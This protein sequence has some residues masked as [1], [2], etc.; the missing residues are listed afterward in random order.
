MSKT[1]SVLRALVRQA[2]EKNEQTEVK[3]RALLSVV[4]NAGVGLLGVTVH[5]NPESMWMEVSDPHVCRSEEE[6]WRLGAV[7]EDDGNIVYLVAQHFV[8]RKVDPESAYWTKLLTLLNREHRRL[9][10]GRVWVDGEGEVCADH[11][12]VVHDGQL[13]VTQ[14]QRSIHGLF[15]LC[16]KLK[17][18]IDRLMDGHD[19]GEPQDDQEED[20]ESSE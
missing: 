9:K 3:T 6:P 14:A 10:I 19:E 15:T 11:V 5:L 7:T 13:T 1:I 16:M 4:A 20:E 2:E 17:R 8:K 18:A 12:H